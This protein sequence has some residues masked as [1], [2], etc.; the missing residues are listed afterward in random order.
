MK[1]KLNNK[2]NMKKVLLYSAM[3]LATT[4]GMSSCGDDFLKLDPTGSVSQGTLSNDQGIDWLLTGAYASMNSMTQTGWMGYASLANYVY[5]D[6]MGADAN[7]GSVAN[8]QTDWTQ[9]PSQFG[10]PGGCLE[11]VQGLFSDNGWDDHQE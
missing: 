6:V 2:D 10:M 1:N 8:D 11:D 3:A 7:K 4:L 5:G 9:S